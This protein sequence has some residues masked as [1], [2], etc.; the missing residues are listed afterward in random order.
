MVASKTSD[1]VSDKK[2]HFR[3][4]SIILI[5]SA[6]LYALTYLMIPSREWKKL[7]PGQQL[8]IGCFELMFTF[9]VAYFTLSRS[10]YERLKLFTLRT[11]LD[12]K[13]LN[14]DGIASGEEKEMEKEISIREKSQ[15]SRDVQGIMIAIVVLLITL[16]MVVKNPTSN[17]K[18]YISL[19]YGSI[20]SLG[21]IITL[22]WVLSIDMFDTIMNAFKGNVGEVNDIRH[23]LYREIGP[24]RMG[25]V[26]Y[27]YVGNALMPI[28]TL[29]VFSLFAPTGVAIGGAIYLFLAYPYYFGYRE[30]TETAEENKANSYITIDSPKFDPKGDGSDSNK[31]NPAEAG[32]PRNWPSWIFLLVLLV[33]AVYT[34]INP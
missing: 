22:C 20:F 7:L 9:W 32:L 33:P 18:T 31:T 10:K 25:A 5:V 29:M 13:T 14:R 8:D 28:F 26:T 2:T 1:K 21:I 16:L 11:F 3:A 4:L 30:V 23:Y 19:L 17:D 6:V 12:G 24:F 15:S 34:M 27:G